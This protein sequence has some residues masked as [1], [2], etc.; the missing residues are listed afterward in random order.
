VKDDMIGAEHG[1]EGVAMANLRDRIHRVL[2]HQGIVVS[3]DERNG[4]VEEVVRSV[5]ERNQA[6]VRASTTFGTNNILGLI[7]LA[8][9]SG[10][11]DEAVWRCFLA[12]HF[13]VY[14]LCQ[15]EQ[16]IDSALKLLCAFGEEPYWTW[17]RVR[18]SSGAFRRWLVDCKNDL[19]SLSYGNHRKYESKQPEGIWEVVESFLNLADEHGGP[20][21]FI[22]INPP[23]H[24]RHETF[25]L[26]FSRFNE[27][28][29]FR[30]TGS[31]DFLALLIDMNL[32]NAE[33][34][35]CYLRG[36]TGPLDGAKKLWGNRSIEEL[37]E[38]A[39]DLARILEISPFALEDALCRWQK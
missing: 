28:R 22:S 6:T 38:L 5:R 34:A 11:L 33:P 3:F 27:L 7:Q 16:E 32:V 30:R 9:D 35:S 18:H 20:L 14:V 26:L 13:G 23:K 10:D 19:K 24:D 2:D 8:R 15:E 39:S 29:R 31:F 1:L 4:F 25:D 17:K 36:A 37:E 21:G 12:A